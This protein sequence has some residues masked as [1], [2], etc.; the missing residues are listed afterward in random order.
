MPSPSYQPIPLPAAPAGNDEEIARLREERNQAA[1]TLQRI[2]EEHGVSGQ[3]TAVNTS[4]RLARFEITL[5]PGAYLAQL[6]A[7]AEE[8]K[9]SLRRPRPLRMLLPIPGRDCAGVEVPFSTQKAPAPEQLFADPAWQAHDGALLPLLLGESV[10]GLRIL[11]LATSGN[12]LVAGYDGAGKSTLLQQFLLSLT[13]IQD[14]ADTRVLLFDRNGETFRDFAKVPHLALPIQK[15]ADAGVA[16]LEWSLQETNRRRRLLAAAGCHRLEEYAPAEGQE[17]LPHYLLLFDEI[18]TL[19]DPRHQQKTLELLQGLADSAATGIHLAATTSTLPQDPVLNCFPTRIWGFLPQEKP[20]SP[21]SEEEN[22]AQDEEPLDEEG[23]IPDTTFL[24]EDG[25]FL[26]CS[27]EDRLR[28]QS[29]SITPEFRGAICQAAQE[30]ATRRNDP[31]PM[32]FLQRLQESQKAL[33]EATHDKE[34]P[35]LHFT[36]PT[37]NDALRA[38]LAADQ[39]TEQIVAEALGVSS[40][41]ATNLLDELS[42]HE[43]L[44]APDAT[45]ARQIQ[46]EKIPGEFLG[47]AEA[48][49]K[50][51]ESLLAELEE[52]IKQGDPDSRTVAEYNKGVHAIGKKIVEEAAEVWMAAEY[53]NPDN[54]S[55]EISQLLYHLMVL[56]LRKKITLEDIYKKL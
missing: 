2:M 52:K 47:K 34:M 41:R 45:G 46:R 10:E 8:C 35:Q 36:E 55:L 14:P 50:T 1:Q 32:L 9:R 48:T 31:A 49:R 6:G 23:N 51:L 15:T 28:F 17:R 24:M 3:I 26:L 30:R 7:L 12:I 20:A 38:V 37:A 11:D 40:E 25:D 27:G 29:A 4:H 16:L 21:L 5:A 44:S 42:F 18:G 22:D 33:Q 39:A 19:M 53:E 56:M 54:V 43:Y 13:L